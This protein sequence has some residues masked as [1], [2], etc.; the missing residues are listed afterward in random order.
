MTTNPVKTDICIIGAGSGGLVVAAV[1]AQL[2][3]DTILIE[4]DK[5]GGDCLNTGC[6]PSKALLAAAH[7]AQTAR[8][9]SR[10]GIQADNININGKNVF[11]H[12]QS[13]IDEIAPHDSV[14]RFE[15]Y[16]VN[17]LLGEGKF[18]GPGEVTVGDQ[19]IQARRFVVATGSGPVVPPIPGL[20]ATPHYT[21]EN[22]FNQSDIPEHLIILGGGPIGIELAQAHRQLGSAVTVLEMASMLPSDDADAVE[23]VRAQL[24]QEGITLR[25]GVKVVATAKADAGVELTV[26]SDAG[27]EKISGSHLLVAAGR[28]PHLDNLQLEKAGIDYTPQGIVVDERLR[29]SN[30]K[31]FAIGDV[32]GGHQFTHIAG[33]HAG[34]VIRNA[35]FRLP[36]KVNQAAYPWVT[37][38]SPELAQVGLTAQAARD[39]ALEFRVINWPFAENDRAVTEGNTAGFIKVVATPKGHILGATIVGPQAGE[40]IQIWGLAISSKLKIGKIAG[41]ISPYPTLGEANKRAAGEFFKE[42]LFSTRTRK[43]VRFL[44]RFG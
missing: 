43:L 19:R 24:V 26:E 11:D 36:S 17:V 13:A 18:S 35:L 25:E 31:V 38:T 14:E 12:V 4:R 29:T 28:R 16:G 44:S 42:S 3:I 6:V 1:A 27:S 23:I 39:Q 9:S 32:A 34:I 21:N 40:L 10:F 8:T 22:I 20:E 33:Y 30:K 7:A 15:D 37:Y 5:M 41:M 2:G